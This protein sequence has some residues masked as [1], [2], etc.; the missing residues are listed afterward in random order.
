M[1]CNL[2][3]ELFLD[4]VSEIGAVGFNMWVFICT[5]VYVVRYGIGA[6]SQKIFE[7]LEILLI[8]IWL[9][10]GTPRF[11]IPNI[12]IDLGI[13]YCILCASETQLPA[14]ATIEIM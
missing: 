13:C 5:E 9:L 14:N 11:R 3:L 1:A 4:P 7:R 8:E 6:I 12:F 10:I 2:E